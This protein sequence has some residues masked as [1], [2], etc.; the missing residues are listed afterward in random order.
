MHRTRNWSS[1]SESDVDN[2]FLFI[3]QNHGAFPTKPQLYFRFEGWEVCKSDGYE[4]FND[5]DNCDFSL[6][7][8]TNV[9]KLK[10]EHLLRFMRPQITILGAISQPFSTI[11][12]EVPLF[13]EH[14]YEVRLDGLRR[15]YGDD[16]FRVEH[17]E[18]SAVEAFFRSA[19][20]TSGICPKSGRITGTIV[21]S[22]TAKSH[23]NRHISYQHDHHSQQQHNTQHQTKLL[24]SIKSLKLRSKRYY[25]P[26]LYALNDA[27]VAFSSHTR[28]ISLV[29]K[30]DRYTSDY[31]YHISIGNEGPENRFNSLL[32][33]DADTTLFPLWNLLKLKVLGMDGMAALMLDFASL[34]SMKC[35]EFLRLTGDNGY[36]ISASKSYGFHG[37][38]KHQYNFWNE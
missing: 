9:T 26:A 3:K 21:E 4:Y 28:D 11:A 35:L 2:T 36:I 37:Y 10:R 20:S 15:L 8:Y 25:R 27:T 32:Q 14:A 22:R 34:S 19:E 6:E 18:E 38:K 30:Y 31:P 12:D 17:G 7:T 5:D 33:D 29:A 24:N 13:C 16:E 1:I 23:V